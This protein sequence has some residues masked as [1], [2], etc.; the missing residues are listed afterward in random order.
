MSCATGRAKRAAWR[1]REVPLKNRTTNCFSMR[2][3]D[4]LAERK[5]PGG[6]GFGGPKV[7]NKKDWE[8]QCSN[9]RSHKQFGTM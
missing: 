1:R 2:M 3:S 9:E 4:G 6:G 5:M 7:R 8:W